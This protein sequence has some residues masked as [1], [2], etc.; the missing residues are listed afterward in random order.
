MSGHVLV[1]FKRDL[2]I[3]DNPAL[4]AACEVGAR[5]LPLYIVEPELWA[6]PDAAARHWRF[7]A[8]SLAELRADLAGLGAPLVV[9]PGDAVQVLGDVTA[10]HAITRIF[11]TEETGNLWTYAR[12]RRVAAWAR[13]AGIVWT[14][15]P[16]LGVVRRLSGRDGWAAG[17]EK[18]MR[19]KTVAV[20]EALNPLPEAPGAIPEARDLGLA[21][22]PCPG[23]QKGG[24]S[25]AMA[26]QDSFLTERGRT[27]RRD[28]SSPLSG[29]AACSRLSPH[30][31]W[32]T[33][34][35]REAVQATKA[36]KAE[37]KGTREGWAGSLKSFEARL[38]WRDHF[39]QKLEDQPS[40]ETRCLHPAYEGLRP[41]EADAARLAAWQ[42]G[43]TGLPFVDACMRYLDHGGWL[44]FR[45]RS[46]LVAVASYHLWLDWRATGPHLARMF[47]D[48]E[49]GIHWPQVQMQSGTTGMNTVRIYNP[50]KQG[51]DQDP[52]G[53]FTRA[54]V[55][56]LAEVPD[57]FLQEPW[58]WEGAG[59]LLGR[60]Y[61]APLV[62][63][64]QAARAARE[65]VWAVRRG[66]AFRAEAARIVEKHASRK[67]G[68]AGRHFVND[69]APRR[70]GG[71]EDRQLRMDL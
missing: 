11:S 48:Y 24:R 37:V 71:G 51:H 47:T 7:V 54:W 57:A 69:R 67:D 4:A 29:A 6:Q 12:D 19:R 70:R 61:P 53:A 41:R 49:P 46:M 18:A 3:D 59:R 2:R 10:R 60:A 55:P 22:D 65:R 9:R 36:R 33:I 50:V 34:S 32:G 38:A 44:N 30:L 58:R 21:F 56:E 17:R 64:A 40:I 39:M 43:E 16:Q 26:L 31:A 35:P 1:W 52:T 45:M 66:D 13:D 20:P 8:E 42:A 28:M 14:E 15:V 27:Y 5:V 25:H 23:R 63:V 62:D 68:G